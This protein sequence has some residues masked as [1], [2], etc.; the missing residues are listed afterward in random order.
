MI[1]L[2][3]RICRNSVLL[4]QVKGMIL[5][6]LVH[7][8]WDIVV[9]QCAKLKMMNCG[10]NYFYWTLEEIKTENVSQDKN[11]TRGMRSTNYLNR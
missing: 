6:D 3:G 2:A 11:P 1:W 9:A 8:R 4:D 10:G 7:K 5:Q